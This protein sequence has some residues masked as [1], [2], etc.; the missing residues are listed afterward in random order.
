MR[1]EIFGCDRL[2]TGHRRRPDHIIVWRFAVGPS[3]SVTLN[4]RITDG[5]FSDA[6]AVHVTLSGARVHSD[7]EGW[8][9][10]AM[11]SNPITCDLKQLEDRTRDSG[12]T[13]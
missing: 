12:P 10:V 7:E 6:G 3:G 2:S 9:D 5:P 4:L 11:V 1:R 8:V 13:L